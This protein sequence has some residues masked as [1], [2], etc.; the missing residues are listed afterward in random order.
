M[1][2]PDARPHRSTLLSMAR[3][4]GIVFAGTIAGNGLKYA[5]HVIVAR[6]LGASLFGLF[7][8]GL[9]VFTVAEIAAQLGLPQAV[10]RYV[11]LHQGRG[12]TAR[13]KGTIVLSAR[14]AALSGL[15]VGLALFLASGFLA[16]RVFGRPELAPVLRIFALMAPFSVPTTILL[17]SFQGFQLLQYKVYVGE[18]LE[19]LLRVVGAVAAVGI[20][21]RALPGVLA[22]YGLAAGLALLQ[23]AVLLRRAFPALTRKEIRPV[24]E[25]RRLAAFSWPLLFSSLLGQLLIVSDAF[26]LGILGTPEQVGIYGAAQ[27]TA[28]LASLVFLSFNAIFAPIAADYH[29]RDEGRD[30]G[31]IFKVVSQWTLSLTIPISLILILLAGPILRLFGPRFA[32]GAGALAV[33][34][35]GWLLH[36]ALGNAGAVL[37]MSGRPRWHLANFSLFLGL[38][39]ALDLVLIPRYGILGAAV[40]TAGSLALIDI[41]TCLE[42]WLLLGHHPFRAAEAKPLLAGAAG[43][44]TMKLAMSRLVSG[45]PRLLGLLALGAIG[46]AVYGAALAALG[47]GREER[48]VL[49]RIWRGMRRSA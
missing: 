20:L 9:T 15:A 16:G 6:Q 47:I 42:V 17:A 22:A 35:A 43:A 26:I 18:L 19:P 38:Q 48:M 37:T 14:A 34:A 10:V 4:A 29:Q 44:A 2:G 46:L 8:L 11:S 5:F 21:G 30:L 13:I 40:G 49:G 1:T 36:S 33:L 31:W 41:V 39:I 25:G 45:P 27:R 12:D 23:A 3:G 7:I 32:G 24:I 28:Q